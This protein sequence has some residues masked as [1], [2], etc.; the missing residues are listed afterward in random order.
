MWEQLCEVAAGLEYREL[1]LVY[2]V[3]QM[4]NLDAVHSRSILHGD[5]TGVRPLLY[6]G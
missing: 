3:E 1:S 4:N 2:S 6:R 5:L